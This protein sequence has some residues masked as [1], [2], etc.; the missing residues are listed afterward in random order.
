MPAPI[1]D[2]TRAYIAAALWSSTDDNGDP[3]DENYTE[4]DLDQASFDDMV[5]DTDNFQNYNEDLLAE[6]YDVDGQDE[7]NAGHNF[8]LTRAGHGAGFWDGDYPA[9]GDRLTAETKKYDETELYVGD[10]GKLYIYGVDP[11]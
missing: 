5:W 2:F 1:D 10:D 9:T 8:W 7:E 11:Y 6:A 3:L 4:F